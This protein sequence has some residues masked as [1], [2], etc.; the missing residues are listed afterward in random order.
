ME[1]KTKAKVERHQIEEAVFR[2]FHDHAESIAELS[3]GFYNASY[4]IELSNG[5]EVVMKVA[6]PAGVEVMTYEKA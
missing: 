1:S 4:L 3:N 6:P 5:R 2:H